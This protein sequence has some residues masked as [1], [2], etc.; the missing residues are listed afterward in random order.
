MNIHKYFPKTILPNSIPLCFGKHSNYIQTCIPRLKKTSK[1]TIALSE[2]FC[3]RK[4]ACENGNYDQISQHSSVS[5]DT[6][7]PIRCVPSI[8][9][10][11]YWVDLLRGISVVNRPA[12]MIVISRLRWIE[13]VMNSNRCNCV[14]LSQRGTSHALRTHWGQRALSSTL[15][16][17]S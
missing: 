9:Q 15:L 10:S 16:L 4:K 6:L 17:N 5:L 2:T 3:C 11:C 14:H 8:H 7:L 12:L 1:T 13:D